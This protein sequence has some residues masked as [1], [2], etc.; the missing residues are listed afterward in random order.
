VATSRKAQLGPNAEGCSLPSEQPR[1]PGD[2]AKL[3]VET[4]EAEY[5]KQDEK[6][7]CERDKIANDEAK[8]SG[9]ILRVGR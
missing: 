3:D 4:L 5:R 7:D 1:S 2:E 8:P 9:R 6:Q